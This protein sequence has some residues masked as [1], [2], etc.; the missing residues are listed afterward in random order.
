MATADAGLNGSDG[1]LRI[2]RVPLA[3]I[4]DHVGTPAYVYSRSRMEAR[5][6]SLERA[7]STLPT[8]I[9]YAAKAN[10]TLAVLRAFA[11]LGAGFD[12]VSAGELERVL[13]AGGDPR[14]VVFSGLGKTVAEIDFALKNDIHCFNVE[15]ASELTRLGTRARLMR[16]T[17]RVSLRVNPD[18]DAG[19]HPYISTG[20]KHNKFGIPI[21]AALPLYQKAAAAEYLDVVGI[22]CHIGSQITSIE[23][24]LEALD[25]VLELADAL[26]DTGITVRHVDLGG[27]FG[28]RY[29]DETEPDI[30]AF[31]TA[32]AERLA[33]RTLSVVLEPGRY[34]VADAGCLLTRVEYL[35]PAADD[36][37]RSFAVV[38]AA[39]N[40][41][42]RPALYQAWHDVRPVSAKP[43][44]TRRQWDLVGPVCES[45]DFLALERD[46][47]LA[48]GDLL[49]IMTCGAYGMVQASNYNSRNRPAEVLVAGDGYSIAR[50]RETYR[51]QMALEAAAFENAR[52]P[53]ADARP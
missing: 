51:H 40:D 17:A 35:K 7:F 45:G 27:G 37:S 36:D 52:L 53:H 1:A 31:G 13:A 26:R 41:L 49:A 39:M 12:I 2:D 25:S 29:R 15:S 46:M 22:D 20:L 34:L 30:D 28:V 9:C 50:H 21:S 4:A 5:Y 11:D 6:R 47:Q 43:D 10:S 24:M 14:R 16:R 19:T 8:T 3:E 32:V 44:G 33:S 48:E 42:L 23:P 18:V 38:D